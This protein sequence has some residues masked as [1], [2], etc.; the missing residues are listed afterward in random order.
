[1]HPPLSAPFRPAPALDPRVCWQGYV[2]CLHLTPRAYLPMKPCDSLSLVSGQGIEGDRYMNKAGYYSEKPEEGR[3]ITLFEQETLEA[4]KRDYGIELTP[5]DHRRN[6]T[7][8]GVPLNH[9]VHRKFRLGPAVLEATRL[10]FPCKH[11]DEVTGKNAYNALIHRSGLNC[12]ILE[13][14]I[15]KIG[16]LVRPF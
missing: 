16:D 10:S 15:V 6:V 4:L 13:G 3:Q 8:V 9:L 14:G 7:T 1:M 12:R 11:L 5:A 2:A